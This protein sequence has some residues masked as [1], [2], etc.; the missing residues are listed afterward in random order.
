MTKKERRKTFLVA[1]GIAI[2]TAAV[3]TN[4]EARE[5]LRG[6][7]PTRGGDYYSRLESQ[8]ADSCCRSSAA[9][10]RLVRGTIQ[11]VGGC[12]GGQSADMLPC[13]S[14]YRWCHE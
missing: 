1:L 3:M 5:T 13:A 11:P 8:C 4:Q 10:M 2:L 14:S 12:A 6:N 9:E 7:R